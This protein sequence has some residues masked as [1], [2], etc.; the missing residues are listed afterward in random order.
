MGKVL[1]GSL[2][3]P[4]PGSLLLQN[5]LICRNCAYIQVI[6]SRASDKEHDPMQDPSGVSHIQ[7]TSAR[8][9]VVIVVQVVGRFAYRGRPLGISST[10]G[11]RSATD[12]SVAIFCFCCC[13]H[14]LKCWMWATCDFTTFSREVLAWVSEGS[15]S[16]R[17]KFRPGLFWGFFEPRKRR[18]CFWMVFMCTGASLPVKTRLAMVRSM[19]KSGGISP[20]AGFEVRFEG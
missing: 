9:R 11:S 18:V 15:P 5:A 12:V 10:S 14:F 7:Y 8:L 3:K 17:M 1:K 4:P 19:L 6:H 16:M 2:R 20:D 13:F